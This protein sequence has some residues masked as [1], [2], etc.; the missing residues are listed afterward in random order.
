MEDGIEQTVYQYQATEQKINQPVNGTW[1]TIENR[2][3][4]ICS[5]YISLVH[6]TPGCCSIFLIQI[7][8]SLFYH[9]FFLVCREGLS[10]TMQLFVIRKYL[11][12]GLT[13]HVLVRYAHTGKKNT[14]G[15]PF[16]K[17]F[18]LGFISYTAPKCYTV[19]FNVK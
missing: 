14:C 17:N 16:S 4:D 19:P 12:R 7:S 9:I 15:A 3:T 18:Y 11:Q 6:L 2:I 10:V 5:I 1:D 13:A 8:H